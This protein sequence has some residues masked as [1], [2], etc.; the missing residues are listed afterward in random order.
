MKFIVGKKQEMTQM[1]REDGKAEPVTLVLAAPV[2][3]SLIRTNEKDGYTALQVRRNN[4]RREVRLKSLHTKD[5]TGIHELGATL[6]VSQFAVGDRV[7]IASVSKSKGFQGG[8]KRHGF[9]GA[10]STHGVKHAHRQPGSIGAGGVQRVLKGQRMAGRMGGER[11]SMRGVRVVNI[12]PD[13]NIIALK[14]GIPGHRGSLVE[15]SA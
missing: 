8:V 12:Y 2:E 10:S 3:V 11:V 5:A 9:H 15:I 6:T 4:M 7:T 14:G 13:Q 1:F